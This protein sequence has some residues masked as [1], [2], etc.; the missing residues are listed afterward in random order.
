M[1][2]T[3]SRLIALIQTAESYQTQLEELKQEVRQ[4][5]TSRA[6]DAEQK[7]SAILA[8]AEKP[9][10]PD[11]NLIMEKAHFQI[12][13]KDNTRRRK[14]LQLKRTLAGTKP[15]PQVNRETQLHLDAEDPLMTPEMRQDIE[16]GLALQAAL[17]AEEVAKAKPKLTPEQQQALKACADDGD[18]KD[19]D[20]I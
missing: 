17:D 19:G 16:R 20:L 13:A 11:A 10:L 4:F 1:P 12:V 6:L 9:T 7:L 2:I 8:L 14:A 3:Q 5:A 18:I 15:R